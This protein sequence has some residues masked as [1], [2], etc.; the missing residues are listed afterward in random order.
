MNGIVKFYDAQKGYGFVTPLTGGG[1]ETAAIYFHASA[2]CRPEKG[3]LPAIPQGAEIR[4]DLVRSDRGPQC[5]NIRL[6][7]LS[8]ALVA[9]PLPNRRT[10]CAIPR[11]NRG[12]SA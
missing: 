4:F 10:A 1:T 6:V 2:V 9:P 3:F 7:K 8:G 5:A 11:S 12:R